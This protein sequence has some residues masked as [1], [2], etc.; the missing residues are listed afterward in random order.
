MTLVAVEKVLEELGK[1]IG[2]PRAFTRVRTWTAEKLSAVAEECGV[3]LLGEVRTGPRPSG[4]AGS[5][6]FEH[7]LYIVWSHVIRFVRAQE[8]ADDAAVDCGRV[9]ELLLSALAAEN[10]EGADGLQED[11]AVEDCVERILMLA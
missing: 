5:F 10:P 8:K 3:P 11:F 1:G 7:V 6:R 2:N 9:Q 4:Q